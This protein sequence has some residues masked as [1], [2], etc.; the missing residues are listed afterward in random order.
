MKSDLKF[1]ECAGHGVAVI[2][3]PTVYENS[4]EEGKTGLIYSSVNEF[5]EKLVKL[6][7]NAAFRHELA[8]NAYNYVAQ[9]RL[10][11]NHY[12]ERAQWYYDM[13]NN[14]SKLNE[15]LKYRTPELF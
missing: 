9:N 4:I 2:A 3:S 8:Q 1:I 14:L 5:E 6:I 15:E 12:K 7:E 11:V 13:V 10:L